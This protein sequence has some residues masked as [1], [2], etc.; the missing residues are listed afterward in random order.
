MFVLV[1]KKINIKTLKVF[2]GKSMEKRLALKNK[3][4]KLSSDVT[5]WLSSYNLTVTFVSCW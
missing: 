5:T 2:D 3:T 4:P 1:I